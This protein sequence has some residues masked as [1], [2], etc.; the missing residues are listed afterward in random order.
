MASLCGDKLL[1]ADFQLV[2][3]WILR[4]S[5]LQLMD[6]KKVYLLKK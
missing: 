1:P 3:D 5:G 4:K 6:D 2:M